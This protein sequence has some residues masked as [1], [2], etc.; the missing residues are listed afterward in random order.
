MATILWFRPMGMGPIR[1]EMQVEI[2]PEKE[3][4]P[5]NREAAI[6]RAMQLLWLMI[7]WISRMPVLKNSSSKPSKK[8]NKLFTVQSLERTKR[9]NKQFTVPDKE[10]APKHPNKRNSRKR[11]NPSMALPPMLAEY[12]LGMTPQVL[13]P[14]PVHLDGQRKPVLWGM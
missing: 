13:K 8:P 10:P 14:V 9:R 6:N 1:P 5:A 12:S 7:L 4:L 3:L 2:P 11:R